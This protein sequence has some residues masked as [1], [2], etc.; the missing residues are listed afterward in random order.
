M[1]QRGHISRAICCRED[2]SLGL[3]AVKGTISRAV[4][5]RGDISLGLYAGEG[6]YLY[7]YMLQ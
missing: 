5:C 7:G 3:Y 2:I 1:L 4:C 6:T